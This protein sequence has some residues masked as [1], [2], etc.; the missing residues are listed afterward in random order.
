MVWKTL[1][2]LKQYT[3]LL[4]FH[5]RG[6]LFIPKKLTDYMEVFFIL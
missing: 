4:A 6:N 3:V 2:S 5:A 1:F